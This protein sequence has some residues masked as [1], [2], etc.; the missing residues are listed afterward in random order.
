MERKI[1]AFF[2]LAMGAMGAMAAEPATFQK[3]GSAAESEQEFFPGE[4]RAR[5]VMGDYTN[6]GRMG[7][8]SGGQD[9]GGS[10]GW[11]ADDRWGDLGN[12][13]FANPVLNA[14]YSDPD[15]IRVGDTY[16][17]TCSEFHF[18]GMVILESKDMVNWKIVGRVFDSIDLPGYSTMEKYGAGSWAPALR[19]HDG[20]LWIY[21]CTPNE[22]LFMTTA[23]K[24][25]GP[26]A[27]LHQVKSVNGWEDPCPLWDGNGNAWLGRSQLGGGP[28]Y[29]HKMSADGRSL[30]DEGCKVYEGPTAEG[31]KLFM[32]DGYYY[33]SIP[34]GGVGTGWQTVLRAKDIYGPW[35]GKRVLEMGSTRVNGPHQGA[36]VDTPEGEWW[37]YHF[38]STGARGRVMHLQP[39]EWRDGFPFIGSDYDGNGIGEPMKICRK[40]ATGV[41]S[42]PSVPQTSDD[43]TDGLGIQW[44]FN[45]NP[46]LSRIAAEDGVLKLKP[47]MATKV[48]NSRNQLTQKLMGNHSVATVKLDFSNL[49]VNDRAGIHVLGNKFMG[50]GVYGGALYEGKPNPVVYVETDGTVKSKKVLRNAGQTYV[51]LRVEGDATANKFWF[52]W[53]LDGKTFTPTN[54]TFE[55][56]DGDWKGVRY[57]LYGYNT[58]A[59]DAGGVAVFDDFVYD[60]DGPGRLGQKE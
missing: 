44:Q 14:D 2:A 45:H 48:R 3:V 28:I 23:E 32:R 25:E 5:P 10:T 55:M 43:F 9:L 26:W 46:D 7:V 6:A 34:E 11:Y 52:S 4:H 21:V 33:M 30:L 22:G 42:E 47:L 1:F 60:C 54:D 37:F 59:D 17:L 19:Y 8:F 38:Q 57:G 12:G 36:L 29:I 51:Y 41:S 53:S 49:A 56:S 18:M 31:T 20:K 27:P 24:P 39:V 58:K 50:L 35:E 13:T 16:Y 15:V 40:P